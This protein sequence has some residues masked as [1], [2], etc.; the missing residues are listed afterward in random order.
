M[1]YS[2][3]EA[4]AF[5]FVDSKDSPEF[6]PLVRRTF[7]QKTL[8]HS[9]K[10]Q[11]SYFNS[12]VLLQ[13]MYDSSNKILTLVFRSGKTYRYENVQYNT[14]EELMMAESAGKYYNEF[15]RGNF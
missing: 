4:T 13:G 1:S 9:N 3:L 6:A 12:S 8:S 2:A 14:W 7:E 11:S 15:I 5:A 10:I